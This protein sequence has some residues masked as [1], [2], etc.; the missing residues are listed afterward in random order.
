[1]N[2]ARTSNDG[3]GTQTAGISIGGLSPPAVANVEEYNGTSWTEVNDTPAAT[4]AAQGTWGTQT[5][6]G[7]A[8]GAPGYKS[9]TFLYDGTS[10]ITSATLNQGRERGAVSSA[11]TTSSTLAFGGAIQP[12][13]NQ[14]SVE[15]FSGETTAAEA[16]DIAFD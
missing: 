14:T 4:N 5:A 2:T 1:M 10:W 7:Y 3:F 12:S 13:D 15:E 11:G 16:A 8:G 6:G 9:T